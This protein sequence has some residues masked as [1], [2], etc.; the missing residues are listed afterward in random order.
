MTTAA[1]DLGYIRAAYEAFAAQRPAGLQQNRAVS[2]EQALTLGER[3]ALKAVGLVTT[4]G[5]ARLAD[6]ARQKSLAEFFDLVVHRSAKTQEVAALLHVD[7]SRIRQRI[8]ERSLFAVNVDGQS[9]IPL[10]QFEQGAVIPG[11]IDVL[12]ALPPDMTAL[13]FVGW[14]ELPTAD[15]ADDEDVPQS[16]R[17]WLLSNGTVAP[18]IALASGL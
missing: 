18:V 15:L 6:Q 5:T 7:P 16:P 17:E 13:E 14:F 8:R 3:L 10:T 12:A 4:V 9:R 11:L 2:P 1:E